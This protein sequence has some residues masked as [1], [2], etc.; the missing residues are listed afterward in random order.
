M[1]YAIQGVQ[2]FIFGTKFY[3]FLE[4]RNFYLPTKTKAYSKGFDFLEFVCC[5]IYKKM[6]PVNK[7]LL[8]ICNFSIEL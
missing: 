8:I 3:D 7:N 5:L 4:I 6:V 2:I 1:T